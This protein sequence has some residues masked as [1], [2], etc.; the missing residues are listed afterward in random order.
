M[1]SFTINT[2]EWFCLATDSVADAHH[3]CA[4]PAKKKNAAPAPPPT[5]HITCQIY[6]LKRRKVQNRVKKYIF[7]KLSLKYD[8]ENLH[9]CP[10]KVSRQI[11]ASILNI[12]VGTGPLYWFE[13]LRLNL[14]LKS[15]A[16]ADFLLQDH[17]DIEKNRIEWNIVKY[18]LFRYRIVRSEQRHFGT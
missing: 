2:Q 1:K 15:A 10:F 9:T 6:F 12:M 11:C 14:N 4:T 5:H 13:Y 16:L 7:F 8:Q 18:T 3:C 17:R